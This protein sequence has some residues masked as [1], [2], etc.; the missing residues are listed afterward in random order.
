MLGER[1]R[2]KSTP[3]KI[4]DALPRYAWTFSPNNNLSMSL[5]FVNHCH[6]SLSPRLARENGLPV[7]DSVLNNGDCS[8]AD[9]LFQDGQGCLGRH[10]CHTYY[11]KNHGKL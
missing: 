2:T 3:F 5:S 4:L 8:V 1:R 10:I 7:A 9:V 6:L 11:C